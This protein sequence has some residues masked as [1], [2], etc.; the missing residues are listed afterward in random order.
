MKT[1]NDLSAHSAKGLGAVV[2]HA[3]VAHAV[4]AHASQRGN[5]R[6]VTLGSV[7]YYAM[8]LL[9]MLLTTATAWA[10]TFSGGSGTEND[11]H[12]IKTVADL[13][14]L[15]ALANNDASLDL[16]DFSAKQ[17]KIKNV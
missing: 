8:M 7:T 12:Q 15:A 16:N 3:V 6:N 14:A 17:T 4:V 9:M 1:N 10:Q 2:A 13:T 11:P 5:Q